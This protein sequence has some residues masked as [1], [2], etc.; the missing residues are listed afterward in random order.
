MPR[1]G[2]PTRD[3]ILNAAHELVLGHGFGATSV[4]KVIE[5]AG[6]TKGTFFYHFKTKTELA[7]ALVERYTN[8]EEALIGET[9]AR[10]EKLSRDPLQQML[11]FVGFFVEMF[12]EVSG[13]HPGCL[14]ASFC[15]QGE[16][17]D[18]ETNERI[19]NSI[20]SSR[21]MVRAKLDEVA[22]VHSPR[23]E[24]DLDALADMFMGVFEGGFVLE[25]TLDTPK[26][27]VGQL[28]QYRNYI[29]LLFAGGTRE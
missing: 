11:L 20:L 13:P 14:L 1:D 18:D 9:L 7:H 2:R 10:A 22:A 25:K 27:I 5:K 29:E 8:G 16:L 24:V 28:R 21:R 4:D 19:A 26:L 12:D 17:I 3:R 6:I 23:L 15:Y